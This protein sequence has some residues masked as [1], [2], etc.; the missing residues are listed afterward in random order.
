MYTTLVFIASLLPIHPD[1]GPQLLHKDKVVHVVIYFIFT[2]VWFP[3]FSNCSENNNYVKTVILA[4]CTGVLIE[5]MQ[6][7]LTK[8][9]S[10]DFYDVLANC[11]GIVLAIIALKWFKLD[12][13][14]AQS[15]LNLED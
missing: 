9:R 14:G 11:L 15:K 12:F 4:F 8:N 3:Y 7:T 2:I 5:A 13:I 1:V 6:E 10:A